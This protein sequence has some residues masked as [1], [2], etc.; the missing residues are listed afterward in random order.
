MS[1]FQWRKVAGGQAKKKVTLFFK[2]ISSR[3]WSI[4]ACVEAAMSRKLWNMARAAGVLLKAITVGT[5]GLQRIT[6]A[7][8]MRA[9][10]YQNERGRQ[11]HFRM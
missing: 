7:Q 4:I 5:P 11:L 2:K 10:K 6:Q 8:L 1:C 9:K 3:I